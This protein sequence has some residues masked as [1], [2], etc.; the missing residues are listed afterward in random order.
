MAFSA[1]WSKSTTSAIWLEDKERVAH[2]SLGLPF[3][4]S[5]TIFSGQKIR[6]SAEKRSFEIVKISKIMD[7]TATEDARGGFDLSSLFPSTAPM[8]SIT[9]MLNPAPPAANFPPFVP[10]RPVY[11]PSGY[12]RQILIYDSRAF[13]GC[14]REFAYK[15]RFTNQSGLT[16]V[17]YR[18]MACRALRHRLQRLMP[19]EK[20]PAVPC[21]AVKNDLLINDPDWPEA[22]DHFCNPL[23]IEESNNRLKVTFER[24]YKRAR[25]KMA[26]EESM[27]KPA[28]N[29][30]KTPPRAGIKCE[31]NESSP[32]NLD[33]WASWAKGLQNAIKPEEDDGTAQST[34]SNHSNVSESGNA[35]S[36]TNTSAS[37]ASPTTS[38]LRL[39][40]DIEMDTSSSQ[41]KKGLDALLQ[42][43]DQREKSHSPDENLNSLTFDSFKIFDSNN[44]PDFN[45]LFSL[46]G[47]SAPS[48]RTPPTQSTPTKSRPGSELMKALNRVQSRKKEK[49]AQAAAAAAAAFQNQFGALQQAS[50]YVEKYIKN[51]W[52]TPEDLSQA[53]TTAELTCSLILAL[54]KNLPQ[55]SAAMRQGQCSRKDFAGEDLFGKTLAI[56]GLGKVGIEVSQR[57]QAF[58]MKVTG[59]DPLVTKNEAERRGIKFR[60]L[61]DI[62]TDADYIS[63]HCPVLPQTTNLVN[64]S[65]LAR[66]KSNVKF[67]NVSK[68]ELINESDLIDALNSGRC[69]GAALDTFNE[70]GN[71]SLME[72]PKVICT[73][74]LSVPI[75]KEAFSNPASSFFNSLNA[76]TLAAVLDESKVQSVKAATNLGLV[77]ASLQANPAEVTLKH[78]ASAQGFK[79]ALIAGAISGVMQAA[80]EESS[81]NGEGIKVHTEICNN[82]ELTLVAGATSVTGFTSPAGTLISAIDGKKLPSPVIAE[83]IMAIAQGEETLSDELKIKS[84]VEYNLNGGGRISFFQELSD[85]EIAD[86]KSANFVVVKF[87]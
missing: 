73:P 15:T 2:L 68:S 33:Q 83:R 74:M 56:I 5:R 66:C 63:L 1:I 43:Q 10:I 48:T 23:T 79:K 39:L 37:A 16:T 38:P 53:R 6:N 35:L 9:S 31:I 72:N 67:V 4:D 61:D 60:H 8:A 18:C 22:S 81:V 84:T 13:P 25:M 77:L 87:S 78:P 28:N 65:T 14:R 44:Q 11:A 36:N 32:L 46:A 34:S 19:R 85:D 45:A 58:G 7:E 59:Y 30:Q 26:A 82:N 47:L 12:G 17:Y 29:G 42:L 64:A 71:R 27:K 3:M 80:T 62:W 52:S 21:I 76:S 86:L 24:G 75:E 55:A 41:P 49:E 54:A 70:D 51:N 69:A 57:M 40:E 20:L 50:E